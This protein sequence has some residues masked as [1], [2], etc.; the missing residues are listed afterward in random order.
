MKQLRWL[1]L[2]AALLFAGGCGGHIIEIKVH[3]PTD[4]QLKNAI[5]R[6]DYKA[7]QKK[8]PG[9]RISPEFSLAD[10]TGRILPTQFDDIN[11]DQKWDEIT[12]LTDFSPG[13]TRIFRFKQTPDSL[14]STDR[15]ARLWLKLNDTTVR[16]MLVDEVYGKNLEAEKRYAGI[17]WQNGGNFFRI[18]FHPRNT[19]DL[20]PLPDSLYA[21]LAKGDSVVGNLTI[22][23][24]ADPQTPNL[25]GF[26]L[27]EN[28][29]IFPANELFGFQA[30][31][32]SR[33]PVRTVLRLDYEDWQ[34]NTVITKVAWLLMSYHHMPVVEHRFY[35]KPT[36][37]AKVPAV[38]VEK[39]PAT[40]LIDST[41]SP[42]IYHLEADKAQ[43]F[44]LVAHPD[45]RLNNSEMPQFIFLQPNLQT[46][47]ALRYFTIATDDTAQL[48]RLA[49]DMSDNLSTPLTVEF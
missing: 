17:T 20:L 3:N 37:S 48:G 24:P 8:F 15:T 39:P 23:W 18:R 34:T 12:V 26:V 35:L 28:G 29:K 4:R 27:S 22:P 43:F 13:Q 11:G 14:K 36:P 30:R 16:P 38:A 1:I 7:L 47:P 21:A 33:G 6:I 45:N 9:I 32:I 5:V 41:V 46:V 42:V 10:E 2:A 44:T 31:V 40:A 49:R 19:I 25:G